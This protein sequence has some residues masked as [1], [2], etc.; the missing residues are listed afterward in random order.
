MVAAN[1]RHLERSD[2][3]QDCPRVRAVATGTVRPSYRARVVMLACMASYEEDLLVALQC[4]R[5]RADLATRV[6]SEISSSRTMRLLGRLHRRTGRGL[7]VDLL[8]EVAERPTAPPTPGGE[9]RERGLA[10]D[11]HRMYYEAADRT[12]KATSWM[13]HDAHKLPL[14][15]WLYQELIVRDR[16]SVVVETGTLHG[17]SALYFAHLFDLLGG[18]RVITIDV[19]EQPGRPQHPRIEYLTADSGESSTLERVRSL[20]GPDDRVMV[21]LD[22]FHAA[23]HV[24]RELEL[25]PDLVTVGC[26]LVVE[27]TN[28]NGNPVR[29]QYGP[30]PMEAVREFR[31][32][33]DRFAPE[34]TAEKFFVT[35][36]PEGVLTRVR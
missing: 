8:R 27:D 35:F 7:D 26:P 13:G 34:P 28:V 18:G 6:L 17:G 5:E 1:V 14:D 11:F 36:H 21:V 12:W 10:D 24:A 25:Y 31:A 20:L 22:S 2:D 9:Q 29:A 30:G 16:V 23:H 33:D 3:G 19:Q 15:L 32:R 4:E